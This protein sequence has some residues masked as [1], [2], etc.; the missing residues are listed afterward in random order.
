MDRGPFLGLQ[1]DSLRRLLDRLP[2]RIPIGVNF[3]HRNLMMIVVIETMKALI[4]FC[5]R[6]VKWNAPDEI[7]TNELQARR[8]CR[9]ADRNPQPR[10]RPSPQPFAH[11]TL[12]EAG[13]RPDRFTCSRGWA[14]CF[15]HPRRQVCHRIEKPHSVPHRSRE[16]K[17]PGVQG[18]DQAFLESR[19]PRGSKGAGSGTKSS[20]AKIK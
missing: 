19:G 8:R 13:A 17:R 4:S 7:A 3:C 20:V 18:A 5:P 16:A 10:R 11:V 14:T 2:K 12:V 9:P 6:D 15:R 1:K